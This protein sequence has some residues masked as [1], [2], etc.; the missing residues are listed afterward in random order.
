MSGSLITSAKPLLSW[1]PNQP[2]PWYPGEGRRQ[3]N[4]L[5]GHYLAFHEPHTFT[6]NEINGVNG[7]NA[8]G[9]SNSTA[10]VHLPFTWMTWDGPGFDL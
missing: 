8:Q 3:D 1:K 4:L 10:V 2:A 5:D 7:S 9:Q 6:N